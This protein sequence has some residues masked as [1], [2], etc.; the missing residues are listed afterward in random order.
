MMLTPAPLRQVYMV[1]SPRSLGYAHYA[2]ESLLRNSFEDLD[3]HLVTDSEADKQALTE[4]LLSLSPQPRHRWSVTAEAELN[5]REA[6]LFGGYPNLRAFRHGHPCWRKVTDPLLLS[7]PGEELVLL[8]PDLYFPNVFRFEKTPETGL[9]LMWQKPNCLLPPEIVRNAMDAK[10]PLAHHVDIG[11]SHWRAAEQGTDL[12]WIE[13][14]LGTLAGGATLP[15][16]MHVEAI[17]WA[18][19]AMREGGGYLDPKLWS[20]WH[21]T[22]PKRVMRKIGFKGLRILKSEPWSQMK[23]FHAGGEAKWW[24]P[25]AEKAGML[26]PGPERLEAGVVQP[27]TE[28]TPAHYGREQRAKQMLRSLGYYQLFGAG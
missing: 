17:V 15:R 16:M 2:L 11:V 25:E 3:L 7:K 5:D 9:L 20:C 8:D 23:C 1:L 13:W 19:I 24:L 27:F 6:E 22:Q 18:A 14:L 10:I 21:R 26:S 12:D 4:A 28:L